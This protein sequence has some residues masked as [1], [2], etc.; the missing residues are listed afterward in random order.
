MTG[1][2][3]R[4]VPYAGFQKVHLQILILLSFS[5]LS[6]HANFSLLLSFSAVSSDE[7]KR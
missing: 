5:V 3:S 6:F 2:Y 4:V 7:E 1:I